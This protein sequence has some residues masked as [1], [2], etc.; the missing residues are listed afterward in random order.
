MWWSQHFLASRIHR[1]RK[2]T[3]KHKSIQHVFEWAGDPVITVT[4]CLVSLHLNDSSVV[5]TAVTCTSCGIALK[6]R[7]VYWLVDQYNINSHLSRKNTKH[8]VD[9]FYSITNWKLWGFG[10]SK[11]DQFEDITLNLETSWWAFSLFSDILE[12]ILIN[13]SW[14]SDLQNKCMLKMIAQ[15][16][17]RKRKS[18]YFLSRA[19]F[20]SSITHNDA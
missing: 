20:Y 1:K 2:H 13:Q 7:V 9:L 19:T 16:Q 11:I 12:T 17:H 5:S 18:E 10:L 15:L 4:F 6:R 14:I 8:L 3:H